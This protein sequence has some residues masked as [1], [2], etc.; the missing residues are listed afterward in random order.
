M[1][2]R[3]SNNIIQNMT[4]N[5]LNNNNET[6][7]ILFWTNLTSKANVLISTFIF[8]IYTTLCLYL[9]SITT[10]NITV[11]Y[12]KYLNIKLGIY[13]YISCIIKSNLRK[14]SNNV[15]IIIYYALF[16]SFNALGY[17]I[18][19]LSP[20]ISVASLYIFSNTYM[21]RKY[22]CSI[23]KS[24]FKEYLTLLISQLIYGMIVIT[25][26]LFL[27]KNSETILFQI[28]IYVVSMF[29]M[30]MLGI[31]FPSKEENPLTPLLSFVV[32]IVM[33]MF[34]I[35]LVAVLQLSKIQ[36]YAASSFLLCFVIIVSYCGLKKIMEGEEK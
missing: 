15:N 3:Y 29:T 16:V 33:I 28:G 18:A 1:L 32:F 19:V 7:F 36:V 30:L 17:N 14:I 24:I 31:I 22:Q 25:P 2:V 27:N 11:I 21:I 20:L 34:I 13:N 10:S 12:F 23:N 8:T 6:Y 35:L 9:I 26:T 4:T 5:F